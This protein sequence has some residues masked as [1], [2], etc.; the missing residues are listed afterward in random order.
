MDCGKVFKSHYVLSTHS[1]MH[2]V[3]FPTT[4]D[5]RVCPKCKKVFESKSYL[6][7]HT[8]MH[9][10]KFQAKRGFE[11]LDAEIEPFITKSN[12]IWTCQVCA[13]QSGSKPKISAHVE[14]MHMD[15]SIPCPKCVDTYQRIGTH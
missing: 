10:R 15:L 2:L 8:S 5:D 12:E 14:S 3:G 6:S 11:T 13:K 9:H 7:K 4:L 1:K